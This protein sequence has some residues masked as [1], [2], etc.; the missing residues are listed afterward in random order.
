MS[1]SEPEFRALIEAFSG[2]GY[3]FAD[4][5]DYGQSGN[6]ILRHDIDFSLDYAVRIAELEAE[7][8]A[9]ATY[10]F[11]L[12]GNFYN[13]LSQ[14]GR[15]ALRTIRSLGHTI[16]LHFDPVAHADLE[17]AFDREKRIFEE[18]F[19]VEI[20]VVSIHRPGAFLDD[21]NRRLGA[22]LHTYQD[23]LFRDIKYVSDSGGAFKH[24][25]PLDSDAFRAR[26][27]IHLLLH[28]IWWVTPPGTPSE[29]LA[30]WLRSSV[31][32]MQEETAF[33]CRAYDG[34]HP[35]AGMNPSG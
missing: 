2:A 14:R 6:L 17:S 7:L 10:F 20:E 11:M 33:N 18:T 22:C 8:G 16:S 23:A 25:H 35:F 31:E 9:R 30:R 13:P 34:T 4:F 19:E 26:S 24:G 29:K 15:A 3:R 28:P 12:S 27:T 5:T 21:R 32:F 1:F